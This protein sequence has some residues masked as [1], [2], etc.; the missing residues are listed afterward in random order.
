MQEFFTPSAD[1]SYLP[2]LDVYGPELFTI[3]I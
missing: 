2:L 1:M 3:D